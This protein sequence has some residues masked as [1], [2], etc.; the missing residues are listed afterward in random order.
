MA[1]LVLMRNHNTSTHQQRVAAQ[2]FPIIARRLRQSFNGHGAI[3]VDDQTEPRVGAG[4]PGLAVRHRRAF[5][6][7][8]LSRAE[9]GISAFA[10]FDA[11]RLEKIAVDRKS[12][13]LNSS[14][15]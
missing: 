10:V 1:S 11:A 2:D 9:Y 7:A 5:R 4:G 13:R 12:T 15:L 8:P 6:Q 3:C 14:H